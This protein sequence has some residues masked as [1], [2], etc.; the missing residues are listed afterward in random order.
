MVIRGVALPPGY[1][2]YLVQ[3]TTNQAF[4]AS[5]STLRHNTYQLQTWS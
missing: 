2:K 5:G 4:P 3:N 1:Y